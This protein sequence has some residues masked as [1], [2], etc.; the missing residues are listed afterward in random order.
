MSWKLSEKRK[1]T[2]ETHPKVTISAITN[3]IYFNADIKKYLWPNVRRVLVRYDKDKKMMSFQPANSIDNMKKNLYTLIKRGKKNNY[4]G[5][6]IQGRNILNQHN[7]K[8]KKKLTFEPH[9]NSQMEWLVISFN[10]NGDNDN[11]G[12]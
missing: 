3:Q 4:Y 6:M 5:L 9:W 11:E 10:N 8:V 1:H 2:K 7:I 12:N